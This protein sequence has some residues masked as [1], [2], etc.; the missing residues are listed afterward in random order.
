MTVIGCRRSSCSSTAVGSQICGAQAAPHIDNVAKRLFK[1][2]AQLKHIA[3]ALW[4][5]SQSADGLFD[6][7]AALSKALDD[8]QQ[9]CPAATKLRAAAAVL[10]G[11]AR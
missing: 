5:L 1:T 2:A 10:P 9:W 3:Q 4:C 8:L 11:S 6:H 7:Y